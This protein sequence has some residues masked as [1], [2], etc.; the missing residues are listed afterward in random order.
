MVTTPVCNKTHMK[1]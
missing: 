1:K